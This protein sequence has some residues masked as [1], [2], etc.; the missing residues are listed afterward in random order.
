M[1]HLSWPT[2][3]RPG[4]LLGRLRLSITRQSVLLS[5]AAALSAGAGTTAILGFSFWWYAARSFPAEAVGFAAA[6][7]SVMNLLA[8]V[9]ELG[10]GTL[11]VGELP[12]TTA[13]APALVSATLLSTSAAAIVSGVAY[14]AF[15]GSMSF[16]LGSITNV[17]PNEILFVLGV[18]ITA[19]TL[20]LD[21][22]FVAVLRSTRQMSRA[23][24]FA[25]SKL[26]LLILAGVS[27][28]VGEADIFATW[29]GG[30]VCSILLLWLFCLSR[31]ERVW[32][33][34]RLSMLR[35]LLSTV[36]R[37]HVLSIVI[38]APGLILPVIVAVA[39]SP[40]TNAAF[41]A[42]WTLVNVVLLVP[43][44]LA[45]VL[46]S[47]ASREPESLTHRLKM[48]L[49]LSAFVTAAAGVVL[50]FSSDLILGLF[51]PLY[52]GIA[53]SSLGILGFGAIGVMA[54]YHYVV[55]QRLRNR[56]L[57]ASALL[58]A[59]GFLEL[60]AATLGA[61]S[62]GLPGLT[63]GWLIAVAVEAVCLGPV[64][65]RALR[66]DFRPAATPA[67]AAQASV[68][69]ASLAVPCNNLGEVT[70]TT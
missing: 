24:A 68:R 17:P 62:G 56:M 12:K 3:V 35:P 33:R 21:Q 19:F 52:P 36:L 20:V 41:Y 37:H 70:C 5:N 18:A 47:V 40:Q 27:G 44:S 39:L 9:S 34:P 15:S 11:L 64:L 60:S 67:A 49:G 48:S 6:A 25:A 30:Q 63:A 7:I 46:Y 59:L 65:I 54:K 29:I 23:T 2:P 16:S 69:A 66:G 53:S 14:L 13:G 32:Y 58:A 10:M 8:L 26:L 61:R 50:I 31:R 42:A 38:Q 55:V 28:A 45:S 1:R 57:H 43:A 51:N 22:A 4:Q